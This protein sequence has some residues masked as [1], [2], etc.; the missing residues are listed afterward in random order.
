M[1]AKK[2]PD[3]VLNPHEEIKNASNTNY[4]DKYIADYILFLLYLTDF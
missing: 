2:P 4:I 3:C 1:K